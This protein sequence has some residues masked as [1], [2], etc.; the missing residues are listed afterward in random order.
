MVTHIAV[1]SLNQPARV[2]ESLQHCRESVEVNE[3]SLPLSQ[4]PEVGLGNVEEV[5]EGG[6]VV[7]CH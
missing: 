7:T 5:E 4:R 1:E 3:K 6:I 2:Q